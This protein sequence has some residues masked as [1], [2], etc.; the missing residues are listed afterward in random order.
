MSQKQESTKT[1]QKRLAREKTLYLYTSALEDGD[2]EALAIIWQQAERDSE[3]ESLLLDIHRVYQREEGLFV[4]LNSPESEHVFNTLSYP[5]G[6]MLPFTRPQ[7]NGRRETP[8]RFRDSFVLKLVAV[9][10]VS[11]LIGSFWL[12]LASRQPAVS[13]TVG[14]GT[15]S[16]SKP[17]S[18]M[19]IIPTGDGKGTIV[20]LRS[21]GKQIWRKTTGHPIAGPTIVVQGHTVYAVS[22]DGHVYAFRLEDG[23]LLWQQT[24]KFANTPLETVTSDNLRLF[25]SQDFLV[26]GCAQLPAG[27]EG[28]IAVLQAANGALRWKSQVPGQAEAN[29]VLGMSSDTVYLTNGKVTKAVKAENQALLWQT[30]QHPF[31]PVLWD[32]T[33][34]LVVLNGVLYGYSTAGL[35]ALDANDGHLIWLQPAARDG[36][37]PGGMLVAGNNRLFLATPNLFCAYDMDTGSQLWC[38]HTK[39]SG[40]IFEEFEG[41][42]YMDGVVYVG[43]AM[44]NASNE[45]Q[46]E[47]WDG[48]SG[49]LLWKWPAQDLLSHDR[50]WTF[51]G[52]QGVLYIPGTDGGLYAVGGTD[53]HQLWFDK[54]F[55][56]S[57]SVPATIP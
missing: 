21:D 55:N 11:A 6:T 30:S 49:K 14:A 26:I 40:N 37:S 2:I 54:S 12:L 45:F 57:L 56:V 39:T 17:A 24:I 27:N 28:L 3:L 46:L 22:L 52:G 7:L 48:A 38:T 29:P 15:P 36:G 34:S 1:R 53:G 33:G 23:T 4:P 5:D 19:V 31:F 9:L 41:L 47:A 51:S 13:G 10:L 25:A 20:A 16:E 42:V 8:R 18:Q 43:R 50:S 35:Q 44:F 32:G